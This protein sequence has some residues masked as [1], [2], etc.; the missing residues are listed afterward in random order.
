MTWKVSPTKKF[1]R[2]YKKLTR[3]TKI[4]VDIEIE[5][6]A[7]NPDLGKQKVGNLKGIYVHKFIFQKVLYLLAY[8]K[9]EYIRVIDLEALGTHQNFYRDLDR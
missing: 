9:D 2:E 1:L 7:E 6:I 3:S 8:S 5:K 4:A